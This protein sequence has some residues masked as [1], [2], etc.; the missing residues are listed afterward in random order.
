MFTGLFDSKKAGE[1]PY[2]E[3]DGDPAEGGGSLRRGRP[4]SGRMGREVAFDDLPE[5]QREAVL[6]AYRR[7]WSL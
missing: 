3:M 7:F 6:D 2:L 5:T 4:P 1:Y